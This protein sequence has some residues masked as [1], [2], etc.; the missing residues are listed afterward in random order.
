MEPADYVLTYALGA[1]SLWFLWHGICTITS[2]RQV[3]ARSR[4]DQRVRLTAKLCPQRYTTIN[5][6]EWCI[7]NV[8]CR[9]YCSISIIANNKRRRWRLFCF[10]RLLL[11]LKQPLKTRCIYTITSHSSNNINTITLSLETHQ[12]TC[13]YTSRYSCCWRIFHNELDDWHWVRLGFDGCVGQVVFTWTGL[14]WIHACCVRSKN[15][16]AQFSGSVY[17][18]VCAARVRRTIVHTRNATRDER[19]ARW[20]TAMCSFRDGC[21]LAAL[22]LLMII[23]ITCVVCFEATHTLCLIYTHT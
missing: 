5:T 19:R 23:C 11:F 2:Q 20:T 12:E 22:W 18:A 4:Y 7:Q 9:C 17:A 1:L 8:Q 3:A 21:L 13:T 14:A 15:I 6:F 10:V 16:I